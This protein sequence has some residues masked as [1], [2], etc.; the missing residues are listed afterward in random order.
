M[1]LT[2]ILL[3]KF[4]SGFLLLSL[5]LSPEIGYPISFRRSS[6]C[7]GRCEPHQTFSP[8]RTWTYNKVILLSFLGRSFE[9][10]TT[11]FF[12]R[13]EY[14]GGNCGPRFLWVCFW[15]MGS[16]GWWI[17][18]R[19]DR[20]SFPTTRTQTMIGFFWWWWVTWALSHIWYSPA[21]FGGGWWWGSRKAGAGS[22][23]RWTFIR[24]CSMSI[25]S[26]AKSIFSLYCSGL[27]SLLSSCAHPLSRSTP[28]IRHSKPA[29]L[30]LLSSKSTDR[31]SWCEIGWIQSISPLSHSSRPSI[32]PQSPHQHCSRWTNTK[33]HH[34]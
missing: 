22:P 3:R 29:L 27:G 33:L 21:W 13:G 11:I 26:Y 2:R 19:L 4:S 31:H 30:P 34:A 6:G 24:Y 25:S 8:L 20:F 7:E 15:T 23:S 10:S 1:V 5:R 18:Q 28:S 16:W 17:S 9:E 32:F 12:R 14:I